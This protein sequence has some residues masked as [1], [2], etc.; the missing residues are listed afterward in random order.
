MSEATHLHFDCPNGIAGDMTLA[1]LLDLGVPEAVVIDA[2]QGLGVPGVTVTV[3]RVSRGGLSA[4][5]VHGPT[6]GPEEPHRHWHDI[7]ERLQAAALATP[8]RDLALAIFTRLA[9]AEARVHGVGV[10]HVHFHEVGGL[11]AFADIVGIAAA[12]TH[13]APASITASPLPL[14]DGTVQTQHGVLPVPAPATVALLEGVPVRPG[15][16]GAGELVTP[17]GAAVIRTL[18]NHFGV[19]PPMQLQGQG[20]GA[21]SREIPG[22]PNVL[23]VLRGTRIEAPAETGAWVEGFANLDDMNPEIGPWVLERLL[24]AGARDAWLEP[25]VMK[26]GRAGVKLGFLCLR[27]DTDALCDVLLRESTTLGVRYHAVQR[28]ELPRRRVTVDTAVGPI[29]VKVGGDPGAPDNVAPEHEDCRRA[30]A[31]T[32]RPLKQVYQL[33][34]VAFHQGNFVETK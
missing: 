1:A 8:V 20:F 13:L 22:R 7:R 23:R 31:E 28:A 29:R 25:V 3:E 2:L 12:I 18:A 19:A 15:P 9:V 26:K 33:A 10:D 5:R 17:T 16:E 4:L 34:L 32:G 27:A 30:A 21:G 14:G 11:D 24:E 6:E